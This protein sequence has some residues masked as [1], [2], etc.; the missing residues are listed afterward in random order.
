MNQC[1]V[2]L[3]KR[4]ALCGHWLY[5]S[6]RITHIHTKYK[7][8]GVVFFTA[9]AFFC[10]AQGNKKAAALPGITGG[11]TSTRVLRTLD[12][13]WQGCADDADL[14]NGQRKAHATTKTNH[15][16][17]HENRLGPSAASYRRELTTR[18]GWRRSG[19]RR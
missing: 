17:K 8:R 3:M 2:Q 10:T 18:L 1:L 15:H 14:R 4:P 5:R 13:V 16:Q 12:R 9:G 19:Q 11:G 7:Q 6:G